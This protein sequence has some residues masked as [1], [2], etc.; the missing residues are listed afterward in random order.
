[1]QRPWGEN[2]LTAFEELQ[3]GSLARVQRE[4]GRGPGP[5]IWRVG[6]DSQALNFF[7]SKM[8]Q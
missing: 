5:G 1:M 8:G 6:R 4:R 2:G 7:I 3:G